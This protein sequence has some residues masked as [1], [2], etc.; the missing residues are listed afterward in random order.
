MVY[1]MGVFMACPT[2]QMLPWLYPMAYPIPGGIFHGVFHVE[3]KK[4]G[5]PLRVAHAQPTGKMPPQ[6]ISWASMV[7]SNRIP[8]RV[9]H[10]GVSNG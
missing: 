3:V 6:C 7:A 4:T 8:H 2:G 5:I 9:P 1:A 10:Y